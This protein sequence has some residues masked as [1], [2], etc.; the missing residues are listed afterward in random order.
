[1]GTLVLS[2]NPGSENQ[3]CGLVSGR[4]N[5]LQI[6]TSQ[7]VNLVLAFKIGDQVLVAPEEV[8]NSNSLET[9]PFIKMSE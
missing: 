3:V 1:M 8:A 4:K 7:T 5:N 6:P 2:R 9:R